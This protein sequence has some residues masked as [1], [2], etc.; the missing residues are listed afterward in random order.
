MPFLYTVNVKLWIKELFRAMTDTLGKIGEEIRIGR[1]RRVESGTDCS[2]R[3]R[4][5]NHVRNTGE[6]RAGPRGKQIST[7]GLSKDERSS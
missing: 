3:P 6:P 4:G 5:R 7:N 2:S 1:R